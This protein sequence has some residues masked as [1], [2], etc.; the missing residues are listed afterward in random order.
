MYLLLRGSCCGCYFSHLSCL[1]CYTTVRLIIKALLTT[2]LGVV[3]L[4][5]ETE[6]LFLWKLLFP[7]NIDYQ[8][9]Y[10]WIEVAVWLYFV[11]KKIRRSVTC[12]VD[13]QVCSTYTIYMLGIACSM[14]IF[15]HKLNYVYIAWYS[16]VATA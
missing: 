4:L 13:S 14:L 15:N 10:N 11:N 2:T 12:T 9:F 16:E 8:Y 5:Q 3:S 7:I 6:P 1:Y